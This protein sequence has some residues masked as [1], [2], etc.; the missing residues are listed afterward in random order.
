MAKRFDSHSYPFHIL[1]VQLLSLSFENQLT[2][3]AKS[4]IRKDIENNGSKLHLLVGE[5]KR[6][7]FLR[8]AFFCS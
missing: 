4:I 5:R 6:V 1:Y 2:N 8:D 3:H 7:L